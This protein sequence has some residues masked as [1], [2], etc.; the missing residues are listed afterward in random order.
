MTRKQAIRAK[1]IEREELGEGCVL[2]YPNRLCGTCMKMLD[3]YDNGGSD[4]CSAEMMD[5]GCDYYTPMEAC[6]KCGRPLKEAD[7]ETD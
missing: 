2:C 7:N 4:K 3:Y 6:P 5:E 1:C